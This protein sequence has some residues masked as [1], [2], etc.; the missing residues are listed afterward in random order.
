M[1]PTIF[2]VLRYSD[3]P[4]AMEWLGRAIGF[5]KQVEFP[6]PDGT[7][8]HAEL[9]RGSGVIGISSATPSVESNP[10]SSVR[11][12]VYVTVD[13]VNAH[14]QQA[15]TAG[16]RIAIQPYDTPYGSREYLG[17]GPRRAPVGIRDLP[18]G[19]PEG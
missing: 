8:A 16:A 7:I 14:H 3:A 13:D 2:P 12:G 10:W 6:G 9:R 19:L 17:V 5:E 1:K 11:Q 15:V 18:H 4:A